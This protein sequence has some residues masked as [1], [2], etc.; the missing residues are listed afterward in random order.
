ML[1]AFEPQILA[2]ECYRNKTIQKLAG[3]RAPFYSVTSAAGAIGKGNAEYF[4]LVDVAGVLQATP[5][6]VTLRAQQAVWWPS[7]IQLISTR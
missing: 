4:G 3:M 2:E 5:L 7:A 1:N 6:C